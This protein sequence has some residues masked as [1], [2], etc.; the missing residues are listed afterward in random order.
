VF[1]IIE[2]DSQFEE[3]KR[4]IDNEDIYLDLILGNKNYHPKLMENN[5]S[6]IY[7]RPINS[8]KGYIL[9]INHSELVFQLNL[10]QINLFLENY[11]GKIF[12]KNKKNTLYIFPKIH[13]K[14]FDIN[15]INLKLIEEDENNCINY[16]YNIFPNRIDINN[17]I[18]IG[19][20]YEKCEN[21]F[22]NL[23]KEIESYNTNDVL[24]KFNNEK[25]TNIFFNIEN[26]GIKLDKKE[27]ID[28]FKDHKTPEYNIEKG[29]IYSEYNLY[30]TTGRPSNSFNSFN[31]ASL[32]KINGERKVFIPNNDC[33]IEMDINGYHPRII[34]ELIDFYL[35]ENINV[36]NYL[37]NLIGISE[38]IK[39][40]T[41]QQIYGG[42]KKEYKD[43]PFFKE[44]DNYTNLIWDNYNKS[45]FIKTDI[46]K[47]ENIENLNPP[48]LLNYIIQSQ[49]TY[50]NILIL[51]NILKLLKNKQTSL[52]LYTYDAF[53]FDYK[54]DENLIEEL[55]NIIRYPVKIKTGRNYGEMELV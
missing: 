23:L 22:I 11:K 44:I 55:T 17:I 20:L 25:L 16:Y 15:F 7:I 28:H 24:Y 12:V 40:I 3:F 1:Y 35:P 6:L 45:K 48:K 36:Y 14:L 50:N 51:D 30:T 39:E 47:F 52:V 37:S 32:N 10:K 49:E 9:G 46:R 43:K 29:R 42:V 18:P 8:H 53:L 21:D 26:K 13:L 4:I 33:F 38:N 2:T 27:Y 19:K 5:L 34:S 54:K 31:F 41:F